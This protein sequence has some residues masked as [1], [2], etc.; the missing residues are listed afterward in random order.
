[1]RLMACN[2]RMERKLDS[3]VWVQKVLVGLV[4]V[5]MAVNLLGVYVLL[6]GGQRPS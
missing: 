1:M 5:L 6:A 4:M 3:C 2:A